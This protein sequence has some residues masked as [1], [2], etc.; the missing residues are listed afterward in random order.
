MRVSAGSSRLVPPYSLTYAEKLSEKGFEQRSRHE[1]G[2]YTE[3]EMGLWVVCKPTLQAPVTLFGQSQKRCS[4]KFI[5]RI[6]HKSAA[7]HARRSALGL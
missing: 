7:Q 3:G 4:R 1:F 2:R 5:S 6:L